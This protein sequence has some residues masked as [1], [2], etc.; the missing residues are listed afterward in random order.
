MQV[1]RLKVGR[2]NTN[3]YI[4]ETSKKN[5]IVIDPGDSAD[6]IVNFLL[7]HGLKLR[8]IA[9][10]HAHF[11]HVLAIN[12]LKA[13]IGAEVYATRMA[14][15]VFRKCVEFCMK[16]PDVDVSDVAA[17]FKSYRFVP[18]KFFKDGDVVALDDIKM[19]VI[20]TPGHSI[21]SVSF[22]AGDTLF[23]GDTLFCGA[24]GRTDVATGNS[25]QVIASIKKL[26][27]LPD[28]TKV[29][30]GHG[31]ESTIGAEKLNN[32]VARMFAAE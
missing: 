7:D 6:E 18:D 2:L 11:D 19:K 1:Y 27:T 10:T 24:V 20:Y 3:C 22:L 32:P 17:E 28:G 26:L 30:P 9:L 13:R 29:C 15:D 31:W 12:D 23:S 8:V 16:L 25:E 21:D 4:L 14:E 5:A